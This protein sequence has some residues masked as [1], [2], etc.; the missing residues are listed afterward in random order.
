LAG[1]AIMAAAAITTI[2]SSNV[3]ST[4]ELSDLLTKNLEALTKNENESNG[5]MFRAVSEET[6]TRTYTVPGKPADIMVCSVK[7][8][9]V[10]CLGEGSTS[11]TEGVSY[12]EP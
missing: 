8:T 2:T 3:N 10:L 12:G 5:Y 9:T 7:E 6:V 11:C 1:L 4:P